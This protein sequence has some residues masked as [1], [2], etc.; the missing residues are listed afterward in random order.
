MYLNTTYY[1]H[2][3]YGAEAAAFTYF[4][5]RDTP[6]KTGAQQLDIAQS[7]M[8]AGI[9]SNP[10]ARNPIDHPQAAFVRMQEVLQQTYVQG[11]ITGQQK[12]AAIE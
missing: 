5:L 3:A 4:G 12:A 8:L 9:P 11:Y 10:S 6:T 2:Q 7:A 1:A